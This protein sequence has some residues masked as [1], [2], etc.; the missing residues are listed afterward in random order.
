MK[1]LLAK[2]I[3]WDYFNSPECDWMVTTKDLH[4]AIPTLGLSTIQRVC[5]QLTKEGKFQRKAGAQYIKGYLYTRR[6]AS[7]E[8]GKP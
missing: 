8:G 7:T 3:V 6:N 1:R 4:Q 2:E 5:L